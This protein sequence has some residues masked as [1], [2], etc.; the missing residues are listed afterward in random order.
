MSSMQVN[1]TVVNKMIAE[2]HRVLIVGLGK[3]GLSCARYLSARGIEVAVTDSREQPPELAT[4]RAELPDVA[5][6]TG[7]F[8]GQVF[9]SADASVI[10]ALDNLEQIAT[11]A[12]QRISDLRIHY[13]L[14]ELRGY[15]YHTGVVFAA[16]VPGKGQAVAQGGSSQW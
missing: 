13:D 6:F 5:V 10:A 15:N 3:T 9:A 4:L 1:R 14:A 11:K 8:D 2:K 12:K 7:G 16:Y